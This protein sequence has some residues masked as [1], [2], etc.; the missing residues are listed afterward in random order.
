MGTVGGSAHVHECVVPG[1]STLTV[2]FSRVDPAVILSKCPPSFAGTPS[3]RGCCVTRTSSASS[4]SSTESSTSRSSASSVSSCSCSDSIYTF[5]AFGLL[6]G[7]FGR[8]TRLLD[9]KACHVLFSISCIFGNITRSAVSMRSGSST[10]PELSSTC[11]FSCGA[12]KTSLSVVDAICLFQITTSPSWAV[13]NLFVLA[14][15]MSASGQ[16]PGSISFIQAFSARY[17]HGLDPGSATP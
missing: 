7:V 12:T 15:P 1:S 2:A 4:S 11:D 9:G 3:S 10:F 5:L 14:L 8:L 6:M 17:S 13:H 16:I